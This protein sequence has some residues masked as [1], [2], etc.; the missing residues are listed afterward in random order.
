MNMHAQRT[1]MT[2]PMAM[3]L[4]SLFLG[5]SFDNSLRY[6]FWKRLL[7]KPVIVTPENDTNVMMKKNDNADHVTMRQKCT[8]L[9]QS[10]FPVLLADASFL[11]SFCELLCVRAAA[12]D[13]SSSLFL[14]IP[15]CYVLSHSASIS[16]VSSDL[17]A[18]SVTPLPLLLGSF[19]SFVSFPHRPD[20]AAPDLVFTFASL[21]IIF[22]RHF[23]LL[24]LHNSQH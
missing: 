16:C 15:I 11:D 21:C 8:S 6:C 7:S 3:S 2:T 12:A 5:Q 4:L 17:C 22:I 14:A 10:S 18:S 24:F 9:L 19:D 20:R 1:L 13:G 23:P